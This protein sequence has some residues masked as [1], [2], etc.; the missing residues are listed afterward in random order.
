MSQVDQPGLSCFASCTHSGLVA[1]Q[2]ARDGDLGWNLGGILRHQKGLGY[3]DELSVRKTA[4]GLLGE[5]IHIH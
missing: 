5:L 4:V 3:T 2:E 1:C